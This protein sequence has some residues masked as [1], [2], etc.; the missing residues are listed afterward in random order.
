MRRAWL[1]L[2]LVLPSGAA[3][4]DGITLQVDRRSSLAWWQ[5]DPHYGQ[6]WATTCPDDPGWQAGEGRS[7]N[8]KVDFKTR[9]EHVASAH[10][11]PDIPM[12][13]RQQ[14]HAVCRMAVHGGVITLDTLTWANTRGEISILPDSLT[15]GLSMRDAYS[16]RAVFETHKFK[17]IH[18]VLDSVSAVQPGD[19]LRAIAHGSIEL[20]GVQRSISTP[21][22]AWPEGGGL[23]VQARFDFPAGDLTDVYEMSEMA[24]AMGTSLGRWE[25]VYMGVDVVLKTKL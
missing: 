6:L 3:A 18:F 15:S 8:A 12:Y 10:N 17:T 5:I 2:I 4:Q 9:K 25:R 21:L 7:A 13:P 16:R 19:T 11:S 24:L 1:A 22:K 14:V 20:H 23:R